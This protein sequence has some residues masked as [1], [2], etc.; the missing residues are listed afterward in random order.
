MP[1]RLIADNFMVAFEIY[2]TIKTK[3]VERY[4]PCAVKLDMHN[5]YD[6]V[7]WKFL[8]LI[9]IQLSFVVNRVQLIMKLVT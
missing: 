5:A 1:D 6:R 8:E 2:H 7:E 3:R 9:L 4:G